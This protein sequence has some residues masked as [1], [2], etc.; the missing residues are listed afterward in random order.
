MDLLVG[1]ITRISIRFTDLITLKTV[2]G[3]LG[4]EY[5]LI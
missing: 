2:P 1:L 4:E 3:I 5:K